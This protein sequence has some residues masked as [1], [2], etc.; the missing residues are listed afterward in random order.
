M[1]VINEQREEFEN[2]MNN[3]AIKEPEKTNFHNWI[4]SCPLDIYIPKI[5]PVECSIGSHKRGFVFDILVYINGIDWLNYIN[6]NYISV[7]SEVN[8]FLN[9]IEKVPSS[10]FSIDEREEYFWDCSPKDDYQRYVNTF[11]ALKKVSVVVV[12]EYWKTK[13][14]IEEYWKSKVLEKKLSNNLHQ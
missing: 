13:E 4:Y 3:A 2:W 11:R 8:Y 6:V 7:D 1:L 12:E 14:L 9:W 10:R 5:P